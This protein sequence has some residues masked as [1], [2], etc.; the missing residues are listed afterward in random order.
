MLWH[1]L[2]AWAWAALFP[3]MPNFPP[4]LS[5]GLAWGWI[6]RSLL[7]AQ[8]SCAEQARSFIKCMQ[9]TKCS[10]F[11]LSVLE[12]MDWPLWYLNVFFFFFYEGIQHDRPP[13]RLTNS[14]S[15]SGWFKGGDD[16][17][18]VAILFLTTRP[19]WLLIWKHFKNPIASGRYTQQQ[20]EDH[21]KFKC[22]FVKLMCG[23]RPCVFR[24]VPL[25]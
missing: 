15:Q 5:L 16:M 14:Y 11:S 6:H 18:V 10:S 19:L 23:H 1:R 24:A 2:L 8:G 12:R 20:E 21:I 9:L 4:A 22:S 17:K 13:V 25:G 7:C 3:L